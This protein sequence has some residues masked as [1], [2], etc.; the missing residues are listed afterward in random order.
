MKINALNLSRL[1]NAEH[2]QFNSDF[3]T[4][5]N[6]FTPAK[7]GIDKLFKKFQPVIS[8]ENE[9]LNVVTKSATTN[10]LAEADEARDDTF[11]GIR[12]VV[13]G[14]THHYKNDMKAAAKKVK[15]VFDTYGNIAVNSYN[16]ETAEIS[17]LV[18]ELQSIYKKEL[19]T[20][21]LTEWVSEF[22]KEND[23]FDDIKNNRYSEEASKIGDNMK[24]IRSNADAL[25]S[26]I[27]ERIDAMIVINGEENFKEFV[28]ELNLRITTYNSTIS[29]RQGKN[30]QQEEITV[31]V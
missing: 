19:Q 20:I 27:A 15:I 4:L 28:N 29:A 26:A 16:Q 31:E 18:S 11:K 2:L 21:G 13:K 1:R 30:K 8:Q 6:K 10:T 14:Y 9:T 17:A 12:D 23:I 25:Y 5:V 7:L 3:I 24:E 22:K